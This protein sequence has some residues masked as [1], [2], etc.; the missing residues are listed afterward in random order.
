MGL[1]PPWRFKSTYGIE[2]A[3]LDMKMHCAKALLFGGT[4]CTT[5]SCRLAHCVKMRLHLVIQDIGWEIAPFQPEDTWWWA[6]LESKMLSFSS[7][8][9]AIFSSNL[10]TLALF[11]WNLIHI[12][13]NQYYI[14]LLN[15]AHKYY[16][17]LICPE[18]ITF[19]SFP[20][21]N[22]CIRYIIWW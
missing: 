20:I 2:E 13:Q 4:L 8:L 14:I 21:Q 3:L 19:Y 15:A 22:T 18:S 10:Q 17:N 16:V 9:K 7:W 5:T 1:W 6:H 12:E 11:E